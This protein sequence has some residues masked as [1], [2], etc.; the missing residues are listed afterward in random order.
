MRPAGRVGDRRLPA[1]VQAM[2][3]QMT[4]TAPTPS[5]VPSPVPAPSTVTDAPASRT[6]RTP[7]SRAR[8]SRPLA[9]LS[10][11]GA[12]AA[13][14]LADGSGGRDP[15]AASSSPPPPDTTS[16][17]N[18]PAAGTTPS[19]GAPAADPART[20]EVIGRIHDDQA[21]FSYVR[22]GAPWIDAGGAW[23]RPGMFTAGQTAPIGPE[24]GGV[25]FNA[26]SASGVPRPAE[27]GGYSGPDDLDAVA[28]GVKT[29]IVR[30]LF[31]LPHTEESLHSGPAQM[32][33]GG[34]GW[35]EQVRLD[36]P[37]AAANGWP[38]RSTT[39]A[40][41]LVDTGGADGGPPGLLVVSIPDALGTQG[42]LDQ[43]I[44]SV[45]VP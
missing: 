26:I 28:A 32:S 34:R 15:A 41:L 7:S 22:L 10:L 39:L 31:N 11:G 43:V 16:P 6:R 25:S 29:R 27:I 35:L 40:I 14:L 21:G 19:S 42:D 33:G 30:E 3:A 9:V 18:A 5:P 8:P 17:S 44:G 1:P 24:R 13:V 23:T 36:F 45:Q 20:S 2:I 38:V 37:Q 4:T 12:V